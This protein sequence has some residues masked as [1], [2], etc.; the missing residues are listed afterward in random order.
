MAKLVSH[1][2]NKAIFTEKVAYKEFKESLQEAYK[3]NKHRF[4]IHGF[5]KGK[6]PR[7]IIE[8]NYGKDVFWN[9]ALDLLLPDMYEKAIEEL[10]LQPVSKPKV[11][12]EEMIEEGKDI[13]VK[14]EVETFPEIEL[15][16]YSNIEI[17]KQN[18]EVD[19]ALVD[20]RIQAEIEKNKILKP[21]E[22]EIEIGDLV[23]I[24]FEGFKD[25]EAFEGGQA[26][27]YELKIG[28]KSFIPGFEEGL[29]GKKKGEEVELNL[30][31]PEEYHVDELKGQEVVFKVKIN[32]VTEEIYPELDDE[33]VMDV[34][35]FDT[36]DEY[37]ASIREELKEALA[38]SNEVKLENELLE[39]VVRRT[40]FD[41]PEAMIEEQLHDELHDYEHQLSH[42]GLD[43][44]TYL[45]ITGLTQEDL[46]DQLRDRAQEK[47]KMQVILDK[48]VEV[49]DYEVSDEEIEKEYEDAMKQYGREFDD[50]FKKLLKDQVSEEDVK[51][52]IQRRKAVE[53]LK[54]NVVFVEPKEEVEVEETTEE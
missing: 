16:D 29:I 46:K 35:E 36:L 52:V 40:E 18:E 54:E 49:N 37:K 15:A 48:L 3:Q 4:N 47:V 25:G 41:V 2:N 42:M 24:D 5:R 23:D 21:V 17:E 32:E 45:Q 43:M 39:E 13:E 1:E 50:D 30:T 22:R 11:D 12:V 28:S 8:A 7:S 14:F 34:S 19:E 53:N 31:F 26:E 27:G 51:H 44:K 10:D 20:E 6:A 38:E 33:F 9:D